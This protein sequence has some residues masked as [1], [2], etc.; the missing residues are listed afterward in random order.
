MT[1]HPFSLTAPATITLAPDASGHFQVTNSGTETLTVH[2]SLGRYNKNSL[3]FPA[4]S[5]ATLTTYSQPWIT[6]SPASFTLKP[7]QSESVAIADHVPAGTQGAHYLNVLFT[8]APAAHTARNVTVHGAVAAN[9]KIPLPGTAHAVTSQG[10]PKAP[11]ATPHGGGSGDLLGALGAV[12]LVLVAV[13]AAV[14]VIV[15]RRRA[16]HRIA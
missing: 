2:E 11:P 10:M 12:A 13:L 6:V 8:A 16:A 7:G 4:A 14:L 9:I 1:A 3:D 15:R 5:H